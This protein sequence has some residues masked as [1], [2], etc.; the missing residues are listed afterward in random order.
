MS[1]SGPPDSSSTDQDRVPA[2]RPGPTLY[3]VPGG[4]GSH[5]DSDL[6]LPGPILG[7]M[8]ASVPVEDVL[9]DDGDE[10]T[11]Y[12]L[13]LSM[14]EQGEMPVPGPDSPEII[15]LDTVPSF[16]TIDPLRPP[17]PSFA[18]VPPTP[19]G[20]QARAPQ[21]PPLPA[22]GGARFTFPTWE[23]IRARF[24]R[25]RLRVSGEGSAE[26]GTK[27]RKRDRAK[28]TA[29]VCWRKL[30]LGRKEEEEGDRDDGGGS[31]AP[32]QASPVVAPTVVF[33]KK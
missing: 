21:P 3:R 23:E 7:R 6:L 14:S 29:K 26:P 28:R 30:G 9:Y 33:I 10:S 32:S 31:Q 4:P 15:P 19:P 8:G 1:S 24:E 11:L 25:L 27:E 17:P 12:P 13:R 22:Q 20:Y 16:H 18:E 5:S 2:R